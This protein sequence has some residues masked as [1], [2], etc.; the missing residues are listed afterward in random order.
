[1]RTYLYNFRWVREGILSA[2]SRMFADEDVKWLLDEKN[3][4]ALVCLMESPLYREAALELGL[5]YKHIPIEDY[6][7][8]TNAQGDKFVEFV[9][10]MESLGKVVDV[11]CD[12]GLGR[13]GCMSA[14][15][16]VGK[17]YS[18]EEAVGKVRETHPF[19]IDGAKQMNAIKEYENY[20]VGKREGKK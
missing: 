6:E 13:T 5:E 3:I 15:Y 16:F 7:A 8:P 17:G 19:T 20:L 11:F 10:Y 1:M 9:D 14:I 4:K 2:S 18:A 12:A